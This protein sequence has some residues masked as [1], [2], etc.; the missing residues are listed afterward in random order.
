LVVIIR[1][2]RLGKSGKKMNIQ[3]VSPVVFVRD[4]EVSKK[5]YSELLGLSIIQD[6]GVLVL[7]SGQFSIHQARELLATVFGKE[8]EESSQ[9][10]GKNNLLLYFET[11]DLEGVF[12]RLQN[13]VKLIHPIKEQ[14]WGQ[15]VFRFYDPDNHV[16]EIG[17]PV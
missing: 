16:I 2:Q 6:D 8:M 14:A 3:F 1:A 9:L 17:E 11:S 7:F 5:F 10:Q 13:Q 12:V 15:K 4:I